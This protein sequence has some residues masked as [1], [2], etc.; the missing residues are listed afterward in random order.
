MPHRE[1]VDPSR[2][3]VWQV[4]GAIGV[5]LFLVGLVKV[6]L[7]WLPAELG[8]QEWEYGTS[9][10]FFDVFPLLGLGIGFLTASALALGR[11]WAARGTATFALLLAVFMWLAF[12]LFAT[13]FPAALRAVGDPLAMT[14]LKKAAAKTLVEAVVYPFGLLWLA[15]AAWRAS[16]RRGRG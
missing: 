7:L 4:F 2:R 1:A 14:P 13:V 5:V 6:A 16:L 12:A 8:E 11:K 15:G 3:L 9:S 10:N